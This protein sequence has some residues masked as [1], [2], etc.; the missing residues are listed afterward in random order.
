MQQVERREYNCKAPSWL[1]KFIKLREKNAQNENERGAR[2]G[3]SGGAYGGRNKCRSFDQNK[4]TLDQDNDRNQQVLNLNLSEKCKLTEGKQYRFNFHVENIKDIEKPKNQ[5]GET[6]CMRFHSLRYCFKELHF[7]KEHVDLYPKETG[8][9]ELFL[10][11][12]RASLKKF[13]DNQRGIQGY[14]PQTENEGT[15]NEV[16]G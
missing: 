8:E 16:Q 1:Q 5:N 2:G 14:R 3:G 11:K 9:M 7:V 13:Q 10:G 15:R 4:G 12:S 6:M